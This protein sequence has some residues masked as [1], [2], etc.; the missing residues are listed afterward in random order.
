MVCRGYTLGSTSSSDETYPVEANL[1]IIGSSWNVTSDPDF[2]NFYRLGHTWIKSHLTD[3]CM[4][5]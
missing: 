3:M 2:G 1:T 4:V 5:P